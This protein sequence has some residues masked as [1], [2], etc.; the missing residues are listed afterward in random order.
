MPNYVI[1]RLEI[2]ADRET[3]QNVMDFLKGKTDEDSTP[4]YI[5]F[6]NIIP[7]PK[8]LLIEASTS[9]EFGMQYIIAQQ[10]KQFNSQDDLKVIQLMEIQEEKVREEAL[11]LGMTYL[12]NWGKYG[13][14]T[15]YEWSIANWGTKW[16]AFNQNFEEPNV[17]WFDTAW[18]GVPLLI[19]TLS[20]IFPDVEFQYAYADED[21]GSNVGKGTIRNGETDMTFPDN[22]SNEAFEIVFFVKPGLEEYLELTDEGYRWKAQTSPD[23]QYPTCIQ[24]ISQPI[25]PGFLLPEAPFIFIPFHFLLTISRLLNQSF[26]TVFIPSLGWPTYHL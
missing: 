15:W 18:E 9:G 22:G 24:G 25:Y 2:N 10:R 17:L 14:P 12:R 16:N 20:E 6:N 13:Y 23:R 11:Q 26:L 1:N 19:Q 21:L 8:D 4:C 3:V 5:D 7:M